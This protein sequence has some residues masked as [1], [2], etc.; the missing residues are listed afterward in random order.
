MYPKVCAVIPTRNRKEKTLRFL[1]SFSKQTYTDL[2]IVIVD[3]N[4][5][6]GTQD[7]ILRR[8]PKI[9]LINVDDESYW[10]ASTNRGVE[11]ALKQN[12]DYILTIN[13]DSY[14]NDD[15]VASLM[16]VALKYD[17]MILGSRIDYMLQP[18]LVWS[19]GSYSNWGTRHILQLSY[20][21]EWFDKLPKDI[22]DKELI[23][24]EALPGNGVLIKRQVFEKIGLYNEFFLAHYHSD[25]ELI[26]RALKNGIQ[27][28][29]STHITVYNDCDIDSKDTR[30][31]LTNLN[32]IVRTYFRK[33]SHLFFLPILYIVFRYSPF[34]KKLPTIFWFFLTPILLPI[35]EKVRFQA[36]FD[37][38]STKIMKVTL[39][40]LNFLRNFRFN[41][42]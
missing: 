26:M 3:A 11:F 30:I 27:A 34:S 41:E 39:L 31:R 10:T 36:R 8:F 32:A 1:E 17:T 19:I 28:Y 6:D 22:V 37:A 35:R 33:K 21:L 15:Y 25:S 40:F 7:E 4:S 20:N 2:Y 23:E 42:R 12:H 14:I 24:V 16:D 5:T 29:C 9:T 38:I 18:D 13:D